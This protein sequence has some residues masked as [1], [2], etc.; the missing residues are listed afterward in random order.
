MPRGRSKAYANR[1]D[2]TGKVPV[3]APTGMP[4]GENKKLRDAQ[5]DIPVANPEMAAPPEVQAAPSMPQMPSQTAEPVVP[6][7]EPT[8]F[9]DESITTGLPVMNQ[10]QLDPDTTKLKSYLPLF[11]LE[12]N[13]PDVP[14]TFKEFVKWLDQI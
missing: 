10:Q 4:Y 8:Q 14:N 6:L 13:K 1:T 2:L 5:K 9:P 11:K 3:N 12:A 7:T